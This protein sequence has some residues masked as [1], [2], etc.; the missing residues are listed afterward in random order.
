MFIHLENIV[1]RDR[2]RDGKGPNWGEF[3]SSFLK[4]GQLQPIRVEAEGIGLYHLIAGFRRYTAILELSLEGK[5]VSPGIPL[6]QIEVSEREPVPVHTKLM[7]EFAENNDRADFDFLEKAKFIRRFHET[8]LVSMGEDIWTQEMTA[9]SLNLSTA[10]IS[11]YLRVEEAAKAD[12]YVAKAATLDAAVKRMK[13]NEKIKTRIAEAKEGDNRSIE[14]ATSI[15]HHGDCRTWIHDVESESIDLVNFDPPWGD[16]TSHKSAENHEA[17]EDSDEYAQSL[18][19]SVFTEIYRILKDGRFCIFWYRAWASERMVALTESFGFNI[20]FTRT[21]CIWYKPDK[22]SDQNRYPEKQLIEAYEPFYL[23]RKGDPVFHEHYTH[24][25]FAFNRVP[26]GRLIH[27]TEKPIELCNTLIKLLTVP[28]E[29]VLDP[30]AGSS[31]FLESAIRN[32]RKAYGCELSPRYHERG[33]ARLADYLKT[34][35][36]E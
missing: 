3:K 33:V 14:R 21:P 18:M 24:N 29:V 1:V 5:E 35:S 16:E 17:F 15:L 4:F 31:A 34:F 13:V 6:G 7:Q 28:G 2:I 22:V 10:S 9:H 8:M 20:Q 27:P 32:N 19:Q 25:V 30:T 12:E 11:H 23:L 26:L 36:E